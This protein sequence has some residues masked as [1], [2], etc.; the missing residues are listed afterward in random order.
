VK[1]LMIIFSGLRQ[2]CAKDI[3]FIIEP[4]IN[5]YQMKDGYRVSIEKF[6]NR[7]K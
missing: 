5:K 3:I 7:K 1:A 2:L 6:N 4:D